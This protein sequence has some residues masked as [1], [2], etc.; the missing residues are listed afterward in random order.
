MGK[1]HHISQVQANTVRYVYLNLIGV[2]YHSTVIPSLVSSYLKTQHT[3][4]STVYDSSTHKVLQQK[5]SKLRQF[6]LIGIAN[7]RRKQKKKALTYRP[8]MEDRGPAELCL[9]T[10]KALST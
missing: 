6:Y 5:G 4:I 1:L 8:H 9:T 3:H 10:F 2:S 7:S